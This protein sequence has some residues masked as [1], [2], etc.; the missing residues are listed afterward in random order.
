[1]IHPTGKQGESNS[2]NSLQSPGPDFALYA[3]YHHHEYGG[4]LHL[5]WADHDPTVQ[6]V[7]SACGFEFEADREEW[8]V[9]EPV[10]GAA[11]IPTKAEK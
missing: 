5:V 9:V 8:I 4:S 10:S 3:V 11:T 1:M 7:I 2:K 6:E